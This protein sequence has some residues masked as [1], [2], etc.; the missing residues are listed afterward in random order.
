MF[1]ISF[2]S[3]ISSISLALSFSEVRKFQHTKDRF[4]IG[5]RFIIYQNDS[6]NLNSDDVRRESQELVGILW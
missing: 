1:S 4:T 2:H 6:V 3:F 5:K